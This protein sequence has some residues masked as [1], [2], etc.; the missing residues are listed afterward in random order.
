MVC[1]DSS[2]Y[3]S[4]ARRVLNPGW[5]AGAITVYVDEQADGTPCY[6]TTDGTELG[7]LSNLPSAVSETRKKLQ[8]IREATRAQYDHQDE[9]DQAQDREQDQ[10]QE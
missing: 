6:R 8:R 3:G 1:R 9:P 7:P 4:P 5:V 2:H 10:A